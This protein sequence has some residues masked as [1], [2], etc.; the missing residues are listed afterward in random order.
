MIRSITFCILF[1]FSVIKLFSQTHSD[2]YIKIDSIITN[3]IQY[4][5]DSTTDKLPTYKRDSSKHGMFP[6][7]STLSQNPSPLIILDGEKVSMPDLDN[8]KLKK[9]IKIEAHFKDDPKMMALYGT[10][11]KNGSIIIESKRYNKR[12][13]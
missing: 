2:L 10:A 8:F 5:Y 12:K 7:F 1:F 11:A 13:K 6:S 9:I 4:V 3:Q